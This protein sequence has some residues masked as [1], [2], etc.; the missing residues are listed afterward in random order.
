MAELYQNNQ[1]DHYRRAAS[2]CQAAG[3]VDDRPLPPSNTTV[4]STN[5]ELCQVGDTK[6][7]VGV[8]TSPIPILK[9]PPRKSDESCQ[10]THQQCSARNKSI[11]SSQRTRLL[12]FVKIILKCLDCNDPRLY[13]EAKQII[14]DCT[15]KNREGIPGYDS[16]ADAITRQLRIKVGEVHWSRAESLMSHYIK[17]RHMNGKLK[18]DAA[19][20]SSST[21]KFAE[22]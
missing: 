22:V 18:K 19:V 14:T 8:E 4:S 16:L 20:Q 1:D 13:L 5:R 12:V 15:R 6:L 9:L 21:P 10:R 3:G 7:G 2:L 11:H 17:T